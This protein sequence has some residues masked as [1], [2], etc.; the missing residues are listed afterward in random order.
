MKKILLVLMTGLMLQGQ[1][2]QYPLYSKGMSTVS[3]SDPAVSNLQ[4]TA[5]DI[6]T[7]PDR[8]PVGVP[9]KISFV[10]SNNEPLNAVP[11]GG[12]QVKIT[13]GSKFQLA[14][15]LNQLPR[16]PLSEY[17]H[18]D[19][20]AAPRNSQLIITGELIQDLPARFSNTIDFSM[21]PMREG[22]STITCQVMISNNNPHV[23][24]SDIAPGNNYI[25]RT[26]TNIKASGMKFLQFAAQAHNCAV[27]MNW[28]IADADKQAKRFIIE[29][30]GDGVNFMPVK[31]IIA[32][33]GSSYSFMLDNVS[34]KNIS[35]RVK[36]E[37][38]GGG[39]VYS[40]PVLVANVC[41]G[42]KMEIILYPNPL[43]RDAQ[44]IT[45]TAKS[46]VFNGKY[47]LKLTDAAGK[48]ISTKDATYNNQ[49]EIKYNTGGITSGNY[50]ITVVSEDGQ[51]VSL[52]F[53][54]VSGGF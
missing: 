21:L 1:A 49:T 20:V 33:G 23:I 26:Y 31:T 5:N 50:F 13:L 52:P 14:T 12:M 11:A 34:S 45:L 3:Y 22:S 10:I 24:L 43:T 32:S 54:K 2:Q 25:S 35:V 38:I 44:E 8:L 51:S 41:G 9:V 29:T 6:A 19:I 37:V 7:S 30:S 47:S 40:K 16:L 36:A 28:L 18:W 53:V 48:E 42:P 27:D 17:F 4:F 46:G 15:G 39:F